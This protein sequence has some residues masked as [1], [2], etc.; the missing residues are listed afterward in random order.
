MIAWPPR[1]PDL[2][3]VDFSVPGYVKDKVFVPSLAAS[4]EAL[5]ARIKEAVANIDAYMVG[6]GMK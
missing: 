5:R 2:T 6:V 3:P 1:S 4:L